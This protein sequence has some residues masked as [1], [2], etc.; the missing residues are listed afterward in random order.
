VPVTVIDNGSRNRLDVPP[1]FLE[2]QTGTLVFDGSDNAL[3]IGAGSTLQGGRIR[4]GTG[5][6]V[7]SGQDCRLASIEI[8]AARDGHVRIG[9]GTGFTSHCRI[10]LHE[11]GEIVFGRSCLVAGGT[12]LSVSDMHSI[13][14][15]ATGRRLNPPR[16]IRL[17]DRVWLGEGV[18]VWKGAS[19]GAGSIIG[20][21]SLVT[22]PIPENVIAA[23]VPA[24]VIR[25]GVTWRHDLLPLD[26]GATIPRPVAPSVPAVARPRPSD[27]VDVLV[28]KTARE[29]A[30]FVRTISP[31]DGLL[32]LGTSHF[33]DEEVA[34]LA[35]Y[36]YGAWAIDDLRQVVDWRFGGFE[37]V[38]RM[39]EFACG[40]GQQTRYL[41]QELPRERIWCSDADPDAVAFVR[42]AFGVHGF[43]SSRFP[44]AAWSD[45]RFDL[46]IALSLFGH[47]PRLTFTAMLGRL[48]ELVAPGGL[49]V[50]SVHDAARAP[51]SARPAD[52]FTFVPHRTGGGGTSIDSGTTFVTEAFVRS[53]LDEAGAIGWPH[54]RLP[55]GLWSHEDLYVVA[56]D[57]AVRFASLPRRRGPEG[58]LERVE[59]TS[60]RTLA[61]SG[62][63][64]DPDGPAEV[65]LV[66]DGE[67][68]DLC[69]PTIARPDVAA[70]LQEPAYAIAGWSS[71]LHV[72]PG[73]ASFR[74]AELDVVAVARDGRT[75]RLFA[76]RVGSAL[77]RTLC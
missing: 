50:F 14:D 53:C 33:H 6:S 10:Y 43:T 44:G 74:D 46:I 26:D 5:C 66:V 23:G 22:K 68:R 15:V 70:F 69:K 63:V 73:D 72:E 25:T 65:R 11:P 76:G 52:G 55:R 2:F 7:E 21:E 38:P 13:V 36:R 27:S 62:W 42:K 39:L 18:R 4:L 57:P 71:V 45:D 58:C 64:G 40:F 29:P 35:Y 3:V 54:V 61:V 49:L 8:H 19:I 24:R 32:L 59:M 56:G 77:G 9:D 20:T 30:T 34:R 17:G 67:L 48:V 47:L 60:E 1:G 37:H 28:G 75:R 31:A 41:V 16:D 51:E 12:T